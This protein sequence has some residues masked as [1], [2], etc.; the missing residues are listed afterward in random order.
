M[1]LAV[2]QNQIRDLGLETRETTSGTLLGHGDETPMDITMVAWSM[3][4]R[5][6]SSGLVRKLP[7]TFAKSLG[8][9]T[10]LNPDVMDMMYIPYASSYFS[11]FKVS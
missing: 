8:Q 3:P 9:F 10:G 4:F 11:V 5:D 7:N 1:A 2:D 6:H